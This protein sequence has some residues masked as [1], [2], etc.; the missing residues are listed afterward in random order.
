MNG[1]GE[2]PPTLIFLLVLRGMLAT[3]PGQELPPILTS[4][5]A[6]KRMVVIDPSQGPLQ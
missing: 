4:P 6:M 5:L 1:E 2:L 3:D